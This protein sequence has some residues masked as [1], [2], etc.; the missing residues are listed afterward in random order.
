MTKLSL[1]VSLCALLTP[2]PALAN[3]QIDGYVSVCDGRGEPTDE[4]VS[5]VWI[6]GF[7]GAVNAE[8]QD[9]STT[10]D[11][12]GYFYL[13]G[14]YNGNGQY[15]QR[16]ADFKCAVRFEKPGFEPTFFEDRWYNDN[17]NN[18]LRHFTHDQN[19][20]LEICLRR[21]PQVETVDT[22]G[23]GIDDGADACPYLADP[24]QADE[25][26]DGVGDLC[27]PTPDG[28]NIWEGDRDHDGYL[29]GEDNCPLEPNADQA[30]ADADGT[31]DHCDES[32]WGAD[33]DP[34]H[35]HGDEGDHP[36]GV[37]PP[38]A[39]APEGAGEGAGYGGGIVSAAVDG[40]RVADAILDRL[41]ATV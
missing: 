18:D 10:T 34:P 24:D 1:A 41:G 40:L 37:D 32:P 39:A 27:D 8:D 33:G 15:C 6:T 7:H 3:L 23:D 4:F 16:E 28:I 38:P 19:L 35:D 9:Q 21:R 26:G 25:D 29:D 12:E 20:G 5:G 30:D 31:G 13:D 36:P 22:D 2:L 14:D 17:N 11:D